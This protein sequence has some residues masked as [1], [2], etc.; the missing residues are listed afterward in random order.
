MSDIALH[1]TVLRFLLSTRSA[2]C[3]LALVASGATAFAQKPIPLGIKVQAGRTVRTMRGGIGASFHAIEEPIPGKRPGGGVWA[4]S[5]WGANPPAE[6]EAAWQS[7]YRHANWLGLDWCRVELE[8]RMY[9]P[10]RGEFTWDNPEMRILYRILDW[11][12]RNG[13]DVFLQQMWG[14]VDWNAYPELR[15]S[16]SGR[17]VSA[18]AS[19][20]DFA[21]GI[22]ELVEHLTR[23]KGY[24]CITLALDHQR[25][26]LGLVLVA[27]AGPASRCPLRP[28][29]AA[30][31]K[32]LDRRGIRAAR[33]RSGLDGSAGTET[34]ADRLRPLHRRLRPA[35]LPRHTSTACAGRLPALAGRETAGASGPAGRTIAA[36]RCSFPSWAPWSSASRGKEPGPGIYESGAQGRRPGGARHPRRRGR[37]QPLELHEPRRPGRPVAAGGYLGP[38]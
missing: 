32:E 24:R 36:S 13:V 10:R 19:M 20:D 29:F 7:I 18:P 35:L 26:G 27:G 8:Q 34:G 17:L 15:G 31:R 38:R 9:E 3:A 22:G 37:I 12:E 25:A 1:W 21:Y 16:A 5:A 14:N 6:D 33:F 23:V 2:W 11:A 4:G 30:V 28:A